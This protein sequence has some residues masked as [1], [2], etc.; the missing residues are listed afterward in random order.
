[1]IRLI[2]S[3][4]SF[5]CLLAAGI[6]LWQSHSLSGNVPHGAAGW[7][8]AWF[9]LFQDPLTAAALLAGGFT[10]S[11]ASACISEML[12][13]LILSFLSMLISALCLLGFMGGH[14]PSLAAQMVKLLR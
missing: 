6:L 4:L 10:F 11:V 12:I 9:G 2:L 1:M 3:T 5:L 7:M 8:N 14:Y 13:G